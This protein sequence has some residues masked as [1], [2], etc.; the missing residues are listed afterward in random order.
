MW[1]KCRQKL[2][3]MIKNETQKPGWAKH[4]AMIESILKAANGNGKQAD[5]KVFEIVTAKNY[6]I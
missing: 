2:K 4:S 5:H 1:N 6:K 3:K